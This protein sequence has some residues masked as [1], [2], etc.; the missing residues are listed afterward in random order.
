MEAITEAARICQE[1]GA[2]AAALR[3]AAAS[4]PVLGKVADATETL[5]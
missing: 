4:A 2:T 1:A 5:R 3:A